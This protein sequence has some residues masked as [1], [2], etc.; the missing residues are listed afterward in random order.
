MFRHAACVLVLL[1]VASIPS[2]PAAAQGYG[3]MGGAGGFGSAPNASDKYTPA[4]TWRGGMLGMTG[5]DNTLDYIT[6]HGTAEIQVKPQTIRVVMAVIS[7]G[8]TAEACQAT[9]ARQIEAVRKQWKELRIPDD[10]IVEDFIAVLPRYEWVHQTPED[11]FEHLM[12]RRAGFRM[13]TNL[14]VAVGTEAEAMAAINRA[15]QEGVSDIIT[16]DYWSPELDAKKRE[17]RKAALAAAKQKAELLLAVFEKRPPVINVQESTRVFFP[18]SLYQTFENV[19]EEQIFNIDSWRDLPRIKAYRP[20][21]TFY[22]GLSSQADVRPDEIA[23]KPEIS[24]VST[25][26]IYYQSPATKSAESESPVATVK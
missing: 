21:M 8:E 24:V 5:Q 1:A 4:A 13:Q 26:T 7:E 23:L 9:N 14:H 10:K 22:K 15:F 3:G 12:Q 25:V 16:F 20:K 18:K 19:L 17:V 6:I 2:S 11:G